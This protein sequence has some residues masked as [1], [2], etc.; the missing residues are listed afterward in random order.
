MILVVVVVWIFIAIGI[1][2]YARKSGMK[3]W[4]YFLLSTFLTPLIAVIVF[5]IDSA[6]IRSR[7]ETELLEKI[8][9]GRKDDRL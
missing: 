8:A 1:G 6:Q 3:F 7:R 9:R 5:A 4:T 2:L